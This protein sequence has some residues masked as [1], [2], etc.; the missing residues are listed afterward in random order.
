[1]FH[2]TVSRSCFIICFQHCSIF[3]IYQG[4]TV[5][6]VLKVELAC[7]DLGETPDQTAD[8]RSVNSL[9]TS[10]DLGMLIFKDIVGTMEQGLGIRIVLKILKRSLLSLV[11]LVPG[12]VPVPTRSYL[13]FG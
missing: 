11:Q 12:S 2:G 1:M 5:L 8:E 13:D 3:S 10:L 6:P 7:A 9:E 4:R